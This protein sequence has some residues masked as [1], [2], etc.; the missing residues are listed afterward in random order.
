MARNLHVF[1]TSLIYIYENDTI[2]NR[3]AFFYN[4]KSQL[5]SMTDPMERT[6]TYSYDDN[7]NRVKTTYPDGTSVS[8]E[9]DARGRITKQTDQHG[10]NTRY[11]LDGADN[12]ISV[13]N[14]Q[15]VTTSYTYGE[16]CNSLLESNGLLYHFIEYS[17][18][19]FT[20]H[21]FINPLQKVLVQS[22]YEHKINMKSK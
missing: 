16:T 12:L 5:E 19:F 22:I 9:Y 10:Y 8:T 17:S 13:T 7:G 4:A 21:Q 20:P 3:S 1:T 2:G 14:A 15:G 6:Y 11:N 18:P